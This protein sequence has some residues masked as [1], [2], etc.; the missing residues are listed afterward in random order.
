MEMAGGRWRPPPLCARGG[1]PTHLGCPTVRGARRGPPAA[2]VVDP[3]QSTP[4]SGVDR[5]AAPR[6]GAVEDGM[7]RAPRMT[8]VPQACLRRRGGP[9]GAR[10]QARCRGRGDTCL[11]GARG[12]DDDAAAE[13]GGASGHEPLAGGGHGGLLSLFLSLSLSLS[14]SLCLSLSLNPKTPPTT[15]RHSGGQR[16]GDSGR[17][18]RN[19]RSLESQQAPHAPRDLNHGA[20][21]TPL[22]KS[23]TTYWSEST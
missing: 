8:R 20:A 12:R 16:G 1:G 21:R 11:G 17:Q 3:A 19:H 2:R 22:L 10:A 5:A 4:R 9:G 6:S 15:A 23:S 7:P 18:G 14:L 13:G